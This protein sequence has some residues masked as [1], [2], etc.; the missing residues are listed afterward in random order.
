MNKDYASEHRPANNIFA[1]ELSTINR[2]MITILWTIF[3][4]SLNRKPLSLLIE[5]DERIFV[6]EQTSMEPRIIGPAVLTV[7]LFF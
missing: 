7:T 4:I 6:R 5:Q 1:H 3:Y 2:A